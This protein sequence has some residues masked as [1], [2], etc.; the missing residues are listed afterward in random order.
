MSNI[1]VA[2]KVE[3]AVAILDEF[4]IDC[5]LVF[6]RETMETGDPVLPLV[7]GHP[8]TWQSALILTRAGSRIAIVGSHEA[9]IVES[10]G[11]WSTVI[12][13]VESIRGPLEATLREINPNR[14]AINYSTDDV[15]AD[16]LSHG[17][18]LI[19]TEYLRDAPWHDRLVSASA[20]VSALRGRKS[21]TEIQRIRRAIA[22]TDDIFQRVASHVNA[23]MSER[24]ISRFMHEQARERGVGFAWD[25]AMCPIVNTGP[26]SM[27]GH[28]V[29]SDDLKVRPG[30]IFHVD[31]GVREDEYCSD[32]QRAW[33]VRN[34]EEEV[35]SAVQHAFDSVKRSIDAAAAM[36]RPGVEGWR[37]DDAARTTL[38]EAGY[39]AYDHATGHQV[40]RSAHDGGVVLGP[41]WERY[42]DTPHYA[43][44]PGNVLTLEL[45]IE[46][47][48]GRGYLGLEEMVLVT[49]TGCEFISNR[50]SEMWTI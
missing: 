44:E 15:K 47:V 37:I 16:G 49:D 26:D 36:L 11:V 28:A 2:E 25:E 12:P 43:V 38:T 41:K 20:I 17:M 27:S 31:F 8:L 24:S 10:T 19:L 23:G 22:T 34:G 50:Q 9:E 1:I 35:P 30:R 21:S 18:Y 39:P 7:L 45:G 3:Q 29:P 40:G 6:V 46:N 4:D 14:I 48:D 5:W 33:Y 32:L 13:Y 42:G